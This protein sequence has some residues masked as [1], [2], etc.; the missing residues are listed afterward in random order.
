MS[1]VPLRALDTSDKSPRHAGVHVSWTLDPSKLGRG[2][3]AVASED[4]DGSLTII[5]EHFPGVISQ[6]SPQGGMS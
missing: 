4:G 3:S 2:F 5:A 6:A 1:I